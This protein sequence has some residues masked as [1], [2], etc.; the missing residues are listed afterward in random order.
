MDEMGFTETGSAIEEKRII[1]RAGGFNDTTS[2]GDSDVI[3]GTD[4][5][6]F[7]GVFGIESSFLGGLTG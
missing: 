1:T 2:G 3:V 6:I 5:K 7:D 4:N